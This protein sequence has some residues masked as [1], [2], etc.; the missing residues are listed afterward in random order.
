MTN[1]AL[2][3]AR[4]LPVED[5]GLWYLFEVDPKTRHYKPTAT[6]I[7]GVS[8]NLRLQGASI[9]VVRAE[10]SAAMY[11]TFFKTFA[12]FPRR[13]GKKDH[14]SVWMSNLS[15]SASVDDILRLFESYELEK[16]PVSLVLVRHLHL[17]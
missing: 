3:N 16:N 17:I 10:T 2:E 1:D 12:S 13:N 15:L 8:Q 6:T 9:P 11:H 4:K 5:R 14:A 7:K